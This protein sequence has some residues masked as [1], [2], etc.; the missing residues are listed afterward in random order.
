MPD[1]DSAGRIFLLITIRLGNSSL[2]VVKILFNV[3]QCYFS[4]LEL[5]LLII[6][7]CDVMNVMETT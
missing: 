1:C 6:L 7:N 2:S 4:M 3:L 5:L